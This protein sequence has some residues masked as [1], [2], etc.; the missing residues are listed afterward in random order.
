MTWLM[1]SMSRLIWSMRH[2]WRL[3]TTIM[4]E[5]MR[6]Q[7]HLSLNPT[8]YEW[9]FHP[10]D[11]SRNLSLRLHPMHSIRL[12]PIQPSHRTQRT[13]IRTSRW[14]L[15][16][17]PKASFVPWKDTT[18]LDSMRQVLSIASIKDRRLSFT[19]PKLKNSSSKSLSRLKNR[20]LLK[21]TSVYRF[22]PWLS[23]LVC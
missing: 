16:W 5:S 14:D 19:T 8:R 6:H 7:W 21:R 11:S 9:I 4:S 23:M 1:T 10:S 15:M 3:L 12:L 2:Y 17:W 13:R 22:Q 20:R 18:T